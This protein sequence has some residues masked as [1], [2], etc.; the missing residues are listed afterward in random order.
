MAF[1]RGSKMDIR[2]RNFYQRV[3]E[4]CRENVAAAWDVR[5][6]L[7]MFTQFCLAI[8]NLNQAILYDFTSFFKI[9]M[10]MNEIVD[11]E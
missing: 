2:N 3:Y 10:L 6:G 7:E 9:F 11:R 4:D 1:L 5:V 8:V